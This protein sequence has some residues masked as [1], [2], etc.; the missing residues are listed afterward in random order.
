MNSP[1]IISKIE[2]LPE[3]LWYPQKGSKNITDLYR[4]QP[5]AESIA[6][7][8]IR[9]EKLVCMLED[10]NKE[11][12]PLYER[13]PGVNGASLEHWQQILIRLQQTDIAQDADLDGQPHA[14]R[15]RY[16][17]KMAQAPGLPDFHY[18]NETRIRENA[19][20]GAEN[21]L[22]E[23]MRIETAERDIEYLATKI[24]GALEGEIGKQ[25][26]RKVI[27]ALINQ[28][29]SIGQ[30]YKE[31][32]PKL[33]ENRAM[34]GCE[35]I[36][37]GEIASQAGQDSKLTAKETEK[38][39]PLKRAE[40]AEEKR[41]AKIVS[42]Q[43]KLKKIQNKDTPKREERAEAEQQRQTKI[44]SVQSIIRR[45]SE[46]SFQQAEVLVYGDFFINKN[47]SGAFVLSYKH[48]LSDYVDQPVRIVTMGIKGLSPSYKGEYEK[49]IG[50]FKSLNIYGQV[51]QRLN[52]DK[53]IYDIV[54]NPYAIY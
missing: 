42:L 38:N 29:P 44:A 5:V 27:T 45:L 52:L 3:T 16:F 50:R 37:P 20:K 15:K 30:V 23:R 8:D 11:E 9:P 24:F 2:D 34:I 47:A 31:L 17:L 46:M 43:N 1:K 25:D 21:S 4:G 14:F 22:T 40:T 7:K 19:L 28:S 41:Q 39:E 35:I 36:A 49:N 26:I 53:G 51:T 6:P 48:P 13:L 54:I 18:T 12:T 32:L 33:V 10:L